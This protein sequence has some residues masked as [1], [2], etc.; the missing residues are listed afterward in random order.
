M[1]RSLCVI[2]KQLLEYLPGSIP[3]SIG[4]YQA[5]KHEFCFILVIRETL[6]LLCYLESYN[7]VE[8]ILLIVIKQHFS[9]LEIPDR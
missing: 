9:I 6:L 4:K 7:A 3:H 2:I 1:D 8:I 5:T